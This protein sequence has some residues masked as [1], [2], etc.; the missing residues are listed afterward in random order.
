VAVAVRQ[1]ARD[2]FQ[3]VSITDIANEV[4]ISPPAVYRY[5]P[6]KEALFL[7]AIDAD[8][9]GLVALARTAMHEE[10]GSLTGLLDRLTHVVAAAAEQHPLAARILSGAE[11][12]APDHILGLPSLQ[13][14]RAEVT[15]LLRLGQSIDLV[16]AELDPASAAL[17]LETVVLDHIGRLVTVGP[18]EQR[19]N[20][21]ISVIEVG[22]LTAPRTSDP[23]QL[24]GGGDRSPSQR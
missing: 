21:L 22:L 15:D 5:F 1:F 18:D 12:V 6:D 20:A 7:A 8:S 13:A 17:A 2:G 23:G 19:W 14:L 4:G 16:R 3:R 9:E 11:R 24:T 10:S